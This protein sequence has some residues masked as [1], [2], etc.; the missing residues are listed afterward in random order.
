VTKAFALL[1]VLTTAIVAGCGGTK[2]VDRAQRPSPRPQ[3]ECETR[4][5]D[6]NGWMHE[7]EPGLRLCRNLRGSNQAST[8]EH[9]DGHSWHVITGPLRGL[10][11]HAGEWWNVDRSPDGKTILAQWEGPCEVPNA[12]FLDADGSHLRPVTGER[13][14]HR[15]PMSSGIGWAKD[16]R[17]RVRVLGGGCGPDYSRPGIY[18]IDPTTSRGQFVRPLNAREGA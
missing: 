15:S 6:V 9:Y 1:L 2:V 18:L 13:D 3:R 10:D 14:W 11:G 7:L 4:G 16:G 12:F 8:I 5:A 17:A